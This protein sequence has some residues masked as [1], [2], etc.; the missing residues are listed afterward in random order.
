[1]PIE[2]IKV[3]EC[4]YI[5]IILDSTKKKVKFFIILKIGMEVIIRT[6]TLKNERLKLILK[7]IFL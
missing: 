1:L 3:I 2:K 6:Q 4:S 5:E 7:K